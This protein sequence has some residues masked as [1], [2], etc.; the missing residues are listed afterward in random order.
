[1]TDK[2]KPALEHT[3]ARELTWPEIDEFLS[4]VLLARL[5]TAKGDRPQVTP[6]WYEWDGEYLWVTMDRSSR[7]YRNL[8]ANPYCA[9]TIDETLGGLRFKA[10]IME[11]PVEL[12]TEPKE[13]V[14]EK[15]TRIYTRYL[16]KQGIQADTPQAMLRDGDHVVARIRPE[17]ILSWDDTEGVA[18]AG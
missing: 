9:V 11:G 7:K 4:G 6:V 2:Q 3:T 13:W 14:L 1:M 8:K 15:V 17:C 10:V 12:I 16:G 5:A 18:P